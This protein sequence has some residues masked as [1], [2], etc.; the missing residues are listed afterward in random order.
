[1]RR[2][3]GGRTGRGG[4]RTRGQYIDLG[5]SRI[6]GQGGQIG[7]QGNEVNDGD[8]GGS[9]QVNGRNQNDEAVNDNIQGNV[10]N[11]IVNND[12]RGCTYKD[13]LS[14]NPKEYDGKGGAKV[15]IRWIE[16]IES[17]QDMSRCRDNQKVK[18]TAG[19]FVDKALTWWNSLIQI[20][21]REAA[22][23]MSWEDFKTLTRD[24]FFPACF[25]CGRT[26]HMEKDCIVA[27]R[28]VN[29]VNARNPIAA[30]GACYECR[31]ID[32]FKAAC[33]WLNQA[34]RLRGN[35]PNQVV[36]NNG[37]QG[38]RNNDNQ[39]HRRVFILGAVEARWDPNIMMGTFT[40]KDHYA[41]T[42]IDSGADYSFVSTTFIPLLSIEPSELR[43]SY[44]IEIASG[45]LVDINKVIRGCKL[46]IEG[47]VFDIDLIPFGHGIF[48]IIIGMDR[49]F[50]KVFPD[51]LS[52]LPPILEIEFRIELIPEV[53][54]VMKSP[55]RLAPSEMEELSGQ[56]KELQDKGS[57]YFSKIDL[58]SGYHQLRVHKD[59]IRKTACRTR[60]GHF[61]FTIMPFDLSNTTAR[62]WIELFSDYD[63][64]IH[65][66]PSKANVV[67]DALSRKE[68]VKPKRIQAMNMTIQSS[69]KDR[70]LAAQKEAS[71]EPVEMQ[72]GMDE[73][74]EYRKDMLKACI[75]EFGG[76]WDVHLPLIELSY[77][78]S[79]HSSVRCAPFEAVYCKK[80]C[81]PIMW[82]EDEEGHLIRPEL[83]QETTKK[84][85]QTKD[86]LKVA[87]DRQK[88]YADERQKPLEF[89]VG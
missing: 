3:T 44:E 68:S 9:N 71:N 34:Q 8:D 45:Q 85:T 5:N 61:K 82:A 83:V 60:Y 15:Y 75:L 20:R 23:G 7:I 24:E 10:R 13:F 53:I 2:K 50:P 12:R 33:P 62:R 87:R 41:I 47:H 63:C 59:D 78:N 76:S 36:S 48:N 32:H 54:P 26:G 30:P 56:L 64:E 79:Y 67:A 43:F 21:S 69:I 42:I 38:R 18:Y 88:G 55:Y 6:D 29:L 84:I 89:S 46:E 73:L 80:C 17:V 65:Y 1:M 35:R 31:G 39:A 28:M 77:N 58:R 74:M 16:K 14:C 66:H 70:I 27:P 52:G 86:R 81:S 37:E 51:D 4:G 19:S 49:D 11:V 22:V 25:N 40:L 57:Q 72:R